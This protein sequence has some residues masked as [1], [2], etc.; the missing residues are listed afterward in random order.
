MVTSLAEKRHSTPFP[1]EPDTT[2]NAGVFSKLREELQT[3]QVCGR[4]K[5]EYIKK[6]DGYSYAHLCIAQQA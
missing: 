4:I 2:I 6:H 3:D 1:I 5:G